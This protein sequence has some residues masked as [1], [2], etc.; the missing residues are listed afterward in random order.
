MARILVIDDSSFSR[1]LIKGTLAPLGHEIIEAESG[2]DAL[3]KYLVGKYDCIFLDLLM[4]EM[5]GFE[6][7]EELRKLHNK[8]P[9]IVL[10]SDVQ[11]TS[12]KKCMELGATEFTNKP[13][14]KNKDKIIQLVD[15]YA[16]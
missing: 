1:K 7:L 16:G 12:R 6:V 8:T 3:K 15:K 9:V 13:M 10:T 2:G 4:P 11:D 5:N 14:N